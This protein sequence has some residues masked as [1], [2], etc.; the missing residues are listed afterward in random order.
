MPSRNSPARDDNWKG[1]NKP[2]CHFFMNANLRN[3]T[4]NFHDV[5]LL[6][7]SSWRQ[8]NEIFPRDRG[9]PYVVL[10]EAYHP[11]DVTMRA[12]EFILGRSGKW[13][14]LGHFFR[15]PIPDRRAEFV[16]GT[17]GEIMRMMSDLPAKV[18]MFDQPDTEEAT[19]PEDDEM[20]AAFKKAKESAHA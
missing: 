10:Q 15:L 12:Q 16:F 13:L 7:L 1:D 9:G 18:C 2:H 19:I 11:D 5:R 8:A 6:S 14:S 17:A 4:N 20:A 3:I